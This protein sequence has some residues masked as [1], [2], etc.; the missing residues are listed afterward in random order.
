[1]PHVSPFFDFPLPPILTPDEVV[2]LVAGLTEEEA[3]QLL[4]HCAKAG[5]NPLLY[6]MAATQW[7]EQRGNQSGYLDRGNKTACNALISGGLRSRRYS[8]KQPGGAA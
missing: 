7:F 5:A 6:C 2:D 4:A 3:G 8:E 1:M